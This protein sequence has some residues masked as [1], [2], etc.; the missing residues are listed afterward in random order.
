M[1]DAPVLVAL[2][3]RAH[4]AERPLWDAATGRP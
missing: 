3:V 4:H 1:G 2:S